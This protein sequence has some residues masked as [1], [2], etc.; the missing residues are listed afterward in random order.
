MC[1]LDDLDTRLSM[2]MKRWSWL[3]VPQTHFLIRQMYYPSAVKLHEVQNLEALMD[4]G[5]MRPFNSIPKPGENENL[6]LLC[7]R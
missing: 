6:E 2:I 7:K 5:A 3:S 4:A 1:S